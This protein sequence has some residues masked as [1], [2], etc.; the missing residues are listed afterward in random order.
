MASLS[1][2][3]CFN[4]TGFSVNAHGG[5]SVSNVG[6]VNKDNVTDLIIVLLNA[7]AAYVVF[8]GFCV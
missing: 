3:C 5:Y 7:N 1:A 2:N 8:G 4:I 6:D